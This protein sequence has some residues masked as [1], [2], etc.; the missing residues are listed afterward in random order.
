MKLKDYLI[1]IGLFT[2]AALFNAQMDIIK[3]KPLDAWFSGWWIASNYQQDWW[4]KY[5]L[6]W[7]VDGWHLCKM[8][9]LTSFALIIAYLTPIKKWYEW[10]IILI[11]WGVLFEI[12]YS[13][14]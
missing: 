4:Q 14:G 1:V 12:F 13:I 5:L 8:G 2:L 3:Y 6:G 10:L 9:M 7:T 11:G